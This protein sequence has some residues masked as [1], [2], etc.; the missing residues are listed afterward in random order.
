MTESARSTEESGPSSGSDPPPSPDVFWGYTRR[1]LVLGFHLLMWVS[2]FELAMQLRFDGEILQPWASRQ[3]PVLAILV[4]LRV[5]GFYRFGLFHGLWRY[6]GM[7]ELRSIAWA[8][9]IPTVI[10]FALGLLVEDLRLPRTIYVGEWLASIVLVGGSRFAI[11]MIRERHATPPNVNAVNALIVGAGDDGESLLRDIQRTPSS[12]WAIRG[13]LDDARSKAGALV[14]DIRVL[15][16]ADEATLSR[17]I[18]E[19]NIKLVILAMPTA[20]GIRLRQIVEVCRRFGVQTKTLPSLTHRIDGQ[21]PLAA[22]REVA[23][24]DLLRR[25]PIQL[26]T[27]QVEDF[28]EGRTVLVTGAGGSIGSE[29][30]RQVLRFRPKQ[31]VLFDH[32]ENSLFHVERELRETFPEARLRVLIGDMTDRARVEQVF[33]DFR[34][35][36]VFH[37]AAHKHVPMM[38]ANPA[39]AVKNNVFGTQVVADAAH[40]F[41]AR[42]FVM[43]STDKAVNPT[44]VMGA[45][46]RIAEMV[47]QARAA[48]SQTRY[49]AVRFGNV[50][51]SAGSVVPLFQEQIEKGGPV[52][53]THP[54]MRRYFMT[55]PEAAQL[56][57]QAGALGQ[58]GEIFLLDMGEA[59]RIVDLARDLIQLSGL[60]PDVDIQIEFTGIRPGEKLFEELLHDH[61]AYDRTPHAKIVVGR[62]LPA[63]AEI[64][65]KDLATLRAVAASGDEGAIRRVL[66]HMVPEAT[67]GVIQGSDNA[68]SDNAAEEIPEARR[69]SLTSAAQHA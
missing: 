62:Y 57:L 41:Q 13:F 43:V 69:S 2:A 49:V 11:R 34:P 50:L 26:D 19:L 18:S 64:V 47:I 28:V 20:D 31:V 30:V 25:A 59:V 17:L 7:P 23:I 27:D 66:S 56:V 10:C 5:I 29:L 3:W 65:Q 63:P 68:A 55:I 61:E 52:T 42:A 16:P 24:E 1:S 45:S 14:R 21:L 58:G 15:G 6:A 40:E 46:K 4:G 38:E 8:S 67:L 33:R 12:P 35:A 32:S 54:E 60:R 22:L 48:T 53:V 37:A 36:V 39:E 9:T 44:S 51:G